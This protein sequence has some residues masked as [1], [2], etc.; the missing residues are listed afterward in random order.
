METAAAQAPAA[1]KQAHTSSTAAAHKHASATQQ[2][3]QQ[4]RQQQQQQCTRHSTRAT[5]S[6]K[7]SI[8]SCICLRSLEEIGCA[9]LM[10][11]VCMPE[12]QHHMCRLQQEAAAQQ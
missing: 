6:K 8:Q 1:Q 5:W 10:S 12:C 4:Q 9:I 11:K 3:Q 7:A 2:Q